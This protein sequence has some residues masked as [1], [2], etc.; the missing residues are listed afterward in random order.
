MK[1]DPI[2]VT[3]K[4][5]DPGIFHSL[6]MTFK[7]KAFILFIVA[8]LFN[9][10]VFKL[11]TTVIPLY[12]QFVLGIDEDSFMLTFML[13]AAFLSAAAFFPLM[14]WLGNKI[15]MRNAFI[16]GECIWIA[17]LLP[18]AFFQDGGSWF[19]LSHNIW[20]I[21]FMA[22]N[23]VGLASA[24]YFVDIIMGNLIPVLS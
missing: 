12:G 22:L 23:G 19:G 7:N 15:G 20:A 3:Q 10:F 8:N 14:R 5:A 16:V 2:E 9:W 6:K 1:E 11:L 21:I 4:E 24:M 17:A 18:F 13:L